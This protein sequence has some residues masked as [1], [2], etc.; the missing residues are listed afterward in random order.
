MNN[1]IDARHLQRLAAVY[2]R[3]SSPGQVRNNQESRQRQR[4]L[5]ERACQLGWPEERVL[6]LEEDQGRTASS[7]HGRQAYH[8]LAEKVVSGRVG[9]ILAVE[10]SRWARDNAAWQLLLRDC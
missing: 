8:E 10:V 5:K 3:Q 4:A 1:Q 6:V 7:T 9:I 2:V